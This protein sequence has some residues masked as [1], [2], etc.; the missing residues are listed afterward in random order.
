MQYEH[1]DHPPIT[2]HQLHT[3][4]LPKYKPNEGTNNYTNKLKKK[5]I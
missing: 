1:Y 5:K 3:R 4:V 2:L